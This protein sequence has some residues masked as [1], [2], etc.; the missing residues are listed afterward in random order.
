MFFTQI[1]EL[2]IT[3]WKAFKDAFIIILL[4]FLLFSIT[5]WRWPIKRTLDDNITLSNYANDRIALICESGG[6]TGPDWRVVQ[7]EGIKE[8]ENIDID[9]SG[10]TPDI[11]LKNPLYMYRNS[12]FLFVG[13]FS[14]KEADV[15]LV[16][17]WHFVGNIERIH[18][19]LPYPK[20]YLNIF[21]IKM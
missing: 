14:S 1:S 15:F 17:E 13:K 6:N 9:I 16:E 11:I 10:F 8:I 2:T 12:K 5:I 18:M 7:Y 4:A 19:I 21:E 3:G 20:K